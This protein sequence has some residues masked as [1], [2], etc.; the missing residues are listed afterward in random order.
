MSAESVPGG[1]SWTK[2]RARG[3]AG[4]ASEAGGTWSLS[5]EGGSRLATATPGGIAREL[6]A[7][8]GG[9]GAPGRRRGIR[10]R[11]LGLPVYTALALL[12]LLIPI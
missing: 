4:G 10:F 1:P 9:A 3:V 12:F 2:P 6:E 5:A 8:V 7:P 11:G